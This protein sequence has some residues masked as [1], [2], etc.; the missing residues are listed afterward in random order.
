MKKVL[1]LAALAATVGFTACNKNNEGT[2]PSKGE[3]SLIVRLPDNVITRGTVEAPVAGAS[4][5]A[6]V[7]DVTVFLLNGDIVAKKYTF[8]ADDKDNRYAHIENVP[9]AVNGVLVLANN[10]L[11]GAELT[12][13]NALTSAAAIKAYP[14]TIASQHNG[15]NI[16]TSQTLMGSTTTLT[17][18]DPDPVHAGRYYK[19]CTVPLNA[20]TARFEIAGVRGGVGISDIELVGVWINH[21]YTSG[22]KATPVQTYAHDDA[23]WDVTGLTGQTVGTPSSA[24][25]TGYTLATYPSPY[26]DYHNL[27]DSR[28]IGTLNPAYIYP[29]HVFAGSNIPHLILLVKGS[30]ANG[31]YSGADKYFMGYVTFTKFTDETPAEITSIASNVIYKVGHVETGIK[32]NAPDITPEPELEDFDLKVAVTI[33]PWTDSYVVPGL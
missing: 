4:V 10:P 1:F 33:T 6:A 32:V 18:V 28:V 9:D 7:S 16:V 30:Y 31:Y 13:F 8:T 22:A 5:V 27:A 3:A 19:E 23:V 24:E 25:F 17:E 15:S 11:S 26:G 12:T 2:D 21:F 20:L 14:F 29:Y